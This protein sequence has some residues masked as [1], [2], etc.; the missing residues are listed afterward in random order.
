MPVKDAAPEPRPEFTTDSDERIIAQL[1]RILS[2]KTFRQADRLKRF[3]TFTV[4]ETMA[5]HGEQLKEFVI[6]MEVFGKGPAF[7]PRSDP[8]VRVQARR[9]RAQL[10]RYYR[11]E[12]QT[13]ETLIELPKGGYTPVFKSSRGVIGKR[14]IPSALVSRNT[15]LLMP[16][17]DFSAAGD[18]KYFCAGLGQEII[19]ALAGLDTI[20]LVEWSG[21]EDEGES[22]PRETAVRDSAAMILKGSVRK[23]GAEIRIIASLVDAVSGCY[24]WSAAFDRGTDDV[25]A[26]QKEIAGAVAERLRTEIEGTGSS[27]GTRRPPGNL[28]AHNL[29]VQGRYHLNQRTEEGLRKALE[30]F[31]KAI[32]EDTQYAPAYSGL[33]DAYGLLGHYGVMPPVEV[34]TKAAAHA[35]WAVLQDDQLAEAHTSLAHVKSTQDWDWAGAESEFLRAIALDP[36]YPTAHHWYSVSCL[37]PLGR[38]DEAMEQILIAQALDPISSIIARDVAVV[39]YY[40]KDLGAALDQCDHTIELN[41]HFPPAYW[42]LGLVQEQRGDFDESAAAF[43]RAIQ[44]SPHSPKMH[45]ALGR[46]FALSGKKDEAK[47]ILGELLDLAE[48]RYVSPSDLASLY[49]ALDDRDS[50]FQWLA[51]A[52][53]DRSFETMTFKVDPRFDPVRD[54]PRFVPLMSQLGLG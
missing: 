45:A 37:A 44:L 39:H 49:F 18:Q 8:I 48:K 16:F 47:R 14:A 11:Q 17:A 24:L 50:G 6:G 9:L 2:S 34:W 26:V 54:D 53:A 5:G 3:L 21:P 43:Q 4:K 38:L 41:P 35:A 22:D 32:A 31:D 7:D 33:S 25:F 42:I 13:D 30:F 36:R 28:A 1:D 19:H 23:A 27:K 10:S 51:K 12:G 46:T 52:F 15:I 40:R 29:Y 20:R